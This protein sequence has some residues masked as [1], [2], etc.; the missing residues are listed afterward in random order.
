[1]KPPYDVTS[2]LLV[3]ISSIS[4]NIGRVDATFLDK[5]SPKLRKQ[6]KIKTIHATLSI[7][8]NILSEDQVTAIM[9][10]KHII[11]P[12]KDVKEVLN[13]IS[14]YD[15]L[16]K[17]NPL[18]EKGFLAAHKQLMSG[19]IKTPGNYRKQGVGI[20]TGKSVKH[21]APPPGNVHFLMKDLFQYLKS[22]EDPALIKACVF[23][24]EME[25][26]HPFLDG[27]GRMGRLWQ[28]LIL[29]GQYPLFAFLP[30]E[31]LISKDQKKYYRALSDSDK[32]G[33]SNVF[34]EYMLN[35][36]NDA[37]AHLLSRNKIT[38][39]TSERI[40]Y[41]LESGATKFTRKDYMTTFKNIST[42]TASRDL[43]KAVELGLV[44]RK[45]EK[46]KTTYL[47]KK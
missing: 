35:V 12:E 34:I 3:L 22:N 39:S 17:W 15:D 31:T 8:G 46:N 1:M 4:E 13:A 33:K 36:I 47:I 40:N 41:F 30:L 5:P 42:A 20:V 19:L 6:N 38:L 25:F 14:V 2:R 27:N 28:T 18:L 44:S 23:H 16:N 9:E 21:L 43:S 29:M 37:L 24:Y 45:G 11:G 26:I 32:Q 10:N 7:E